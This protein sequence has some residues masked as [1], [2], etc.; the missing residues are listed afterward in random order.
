[1]ESELEERST[2]PGVRRQGSSG[3]LCGSG[4]GN[5]GWIFSQLQQLVQSVNLDALADLEG[6]APA[7]ILQCLPGPD[8]RGPVGVAVW[9]P[10]QDGVGPEGGYAVLYEQAPD[11]M[12]DVRD[13]HW[14]V[15][16]MCWIRHIG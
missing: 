5:R 3:H 2:S 15:F 1:M 16:S 10:H 6:V 13:R 7:G 4:G 8:R 11:V 9:L 12:M 14:A